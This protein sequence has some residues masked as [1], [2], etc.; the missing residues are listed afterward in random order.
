MWEISGGNIV[1][2]A[3]AT[4]WTSAQTSTTGI[5]A[6]AL[7]GIREIRHLFAS[8]TS[9]S[10]GTSSG[11]NELD[12]V[13]LGEIQALRKS[14]L[15]GTYDRPKLYAVTRLQ[16]ATPAA[17][18]VSDVGKLQL[19]YWPTVTGFYFPG[20][21]IPEFTPMDGGASDCPAV[22]DLEAYDIAWIAAADLAV[23]IGRQHLVPSLLMKVSE[24][25]AAALDRKLKSLLS[26]D[27]SK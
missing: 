6:G 23:R 1:T 13:D 2:A 27:Q 25:T 21:Y 4:L 16:P 18:G 8:T 11:D 15:T 24:T 26:G 3:S 22:N 20:I 17:A 12:P 9:G 10:T 19:D 5:V 7:A 14:N